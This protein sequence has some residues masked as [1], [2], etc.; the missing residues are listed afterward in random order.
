MNKQYKLKFN[1]STLSLD[2]VSELAT[3]A[4][5]GKVASSEAIENNSHSQD[6]ANSHRPLLS[7]LTTNLFLS[8]LVG[9]TVVPSFASTARTGM[10]VVCGTAVVSEINNL[11]QI[12][13]ST[14]KTIIN[15]NTFNIQQDEIVKFV[16]ANA[17][18]AVLN[19]V[20]G[21]S[22][23][24]I[25]GQLQSNGAVFIVNPA[26]VVFGKNSVVDV[27]HLVAS[28]L[29]IADQDFINGKYV[30]NQDKDKAIA[31]ILAQ[32]MIKVKEDGTLALIGGNVINTGALQAKNGTV[33]LLAGNSIT[34]SDLTNPN[35]SYTV[36]A[37]NRAVNLGEIVAKKAVL[38]AS[39]VAN[40]YTSATEFA[41]IMS[42][43]STSAS[44]ATINAN[45]EVVLYGATEGVNTNLS[46]TNE[47]AQGNTDSSLVINNGT[48]NVSNTTGTGGKVQVLGNKVVLEGNSHINASGAQG[49]IV[50]V[51][52]DKQGKG[53]IKLSNNT[54][55]TNS[56]VINVSSTEG[57]AGE[58]YFWG[59]YA[60]VNGSFLGLSTNGKGAFVETS[61][62]TLGL[63]TKVYV[64]TLATNGTT[65]KW[66]IDPNQA[67]ISKGDTA[68]NP[69]TGA[70]YDQTISNALA[71]TDVEIWALY[72]ITT[73]IQA[74]ITWTS[75]TTL[76]ITVNGTNTTELNK[77]DNRVFL[78]RTTING[79]DTG[80]L[81]INSNNNVTLVG[82]NFTL[83]SLTINSKSTKY[84]SL[85]EYSTIKVKDEFRLVAGI[86]ID[87]G[88]KTNSGFFS[89]ITAGSVYVEAQGDW[90]FQVNNRSSITATTGD[91]TLVH[92]GN[93]PSNTSANVLGIYGATLTAVCGS[94]N[95]KSTNSS[96][97][98]SGSNI[99][100]YKDFI[101]EG[102][103]Y[104]I[105]NSTFNSTGGN[106]SINE[107]IAT[108]G[109]KVNLSA[110]KDVTVINSSDLILDDRYCISAGQDIIF[111]AGNNVNFTRAFN[112]SNPNG[113][114]IANGS[115]VNVISAT[116][117]AAGGHLQLGNASTTEVTVNNSNLKAGQDVLLRG[118]DLVNVSGT[119][120][121]AGRDLNLSAPT[122]TVCVSN[123][124]FAV[125]RSINLTAQTITLGAGTNVSASNIGAEATTFTST[126]SNLSAANDLNIVATD[127]TVTGSKL[128]S[129][130][131]AVNLNGSTSVNINDTSINAATNATIAGGSTT[132]T[133]INISAG[134]KTSLTG[135]T[136]T[137]SNSNIAGSDVEVVAET[138][139]VTI[140]GGVLNATTG[141]ASVKSATGTV[142]ITDGAQVKA[143]NGQAGI[144]ANK[145][146]ANNAVICATDV[147][148]SGTESVSL[149]NNT[150][151]NATTGDA[152]VT[153]GTVTSDGTNITAGKQ[154]AVTGTS[155][156]LNNTNISG[157]DVALN[158]TT[159]DVTIGNSSLN[160]TAGNLSVNAT[161]NAVVKDGTKLEAKEG[162]AN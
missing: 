86:G 94:V 7:R 160:A 106:I 138:G 5:T 27:N 147:T 102:T 57:N 43:Y 96:V 51:G 152:Q 24:Q 144:T 41:D 25:L 75:G 74:N 145:I 118:N 155:V 146:N 123:T 10:E 66:L 40:G 55:D 104:N 85:I 127:I 117:N 52:G 3:N 15:W 143:A 140:K 90:A 64:N 59:N 47:Q 80:S 30:F 77:Q 105:D 156:T 68:N 21:G 97:N 12:T 149:G 154:A 128:N 62:H 103:K 114:I 56:S 79:G 22:I 108:V 162:A 44:S 119:S 2:A 6:N 158:A 135:S 115:K 116:L 92:S 54:Q 8:A 121:T 136:V 98:I 95:L 13:T 78:N 63:G 82:V 122:G 38:A 19:R 58:I 31:N 36:T 113:S 28:T 17:D 133:N 20:I 139:D 150:I 153:G 111:T 84:N 29:D 151:I 16:Q 70:W 67:A 130:E 107:D 26:G 35:I 33:Y 18:S 4:I 157:K 65:G 11:T 32:G 112:L 142:T 83:K 93:T 159:G 42:N 45:G 101:I 126:G 100:S 9:T 110:A 1:R 81:V 134:N 109:P 87:I 14:N 49:G 131:G 161:G 71:T 39:K 48:I 91:I 132:V 46:A 129:S 137:A 125:T 37:T 73:A 69:D 124:S 99:T 88:C 72:R 50:Y 141:N 23:S 89:T 76:T 61:G 60:K 34:I 148:L 120:V 53:N